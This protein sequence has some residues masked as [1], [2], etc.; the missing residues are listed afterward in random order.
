MFKRKSNRNRIFK[1]GPLLL[2]ALLAVLL[3]AIAAPPSSAQQKSVNV[4]DQ[5]AANAEKSTT[6]SRVE[7][8]ELGID[9]SGSNGSWRASELSDGTVVLTFG[10]IYLAS[11]YGE[12]VRYATGIGEDEGRS[13]AEISHEAIQQSWYCEVYLGDSTSIVGSYIRT[14]YSVFCYDVARHR[15][16][17]QFQRSSWS[18]YRDYTD[19]VTGGW[20]SGVANGQNIEAYC[21]G[22]GTYD[23]RGRFISVVQPT[24]G[25]TRTSPA[26]VTGIGRFPC[27]TG[28][29]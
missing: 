24:L 19:W 25:D 1:R 14:K 27:G 26:Y 20:V 18:G 5:G 22:G 7:A 2:S 23:Y 4:S 21:G 12:V 29:S 8:V 9:P 10:N 17:W 16:D 3:V 13:L 6:P 15:V 28:V 11:K